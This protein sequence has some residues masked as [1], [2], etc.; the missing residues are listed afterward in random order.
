M[1]EPLSF[2]IVCEHLRHFTNPNGKA[3]KY[4]FMAAYRLFL[5]ITAN[6]QEHGLEAVPLQMA[7]E[8]TNAHQEFLEA[9]VTLLGRS[10]TERR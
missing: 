10:D 8:T 6:L 4:D 3:D 7:R 1:D 9:L 2:S 5:A